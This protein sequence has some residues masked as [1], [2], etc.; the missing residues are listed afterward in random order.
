[1]RYLYRRTRPHIETLLYVF[2]LALGES[3]L[4]S[5]RKKYEAKCATSIVGRAHTMKLYCM[6][7]VWR[8]GKA[9]SRHSEKKGTKNAT[10][11]VARAHTITLCAFLLTGSR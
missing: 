4:P 11:I 2:L 7:F 10:S 6:C 1:M 9:S 3:E 5:F 8:W